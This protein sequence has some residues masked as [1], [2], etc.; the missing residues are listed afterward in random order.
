MEKMEQSAVKTLRAMGAAAAAAVAPIL[1]HP[2]P[3]VHDSENMLDD[4]LE[5]ARKLRRLSAAHALRQ[6]GEEISHT[7]APAV[8]QCMLD[9]DPEIRKE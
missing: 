6:L 1:T 7:Q 4:E 2:A 9:P 3:P 8:A 5:A